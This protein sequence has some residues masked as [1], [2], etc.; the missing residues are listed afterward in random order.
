MPQAGRNDAPCGRKEFDAVILS[1]IVAGGDLDAAGRAALA[2]EHAC[3]GRG[4]D[5]GVDGVS[6]HGLQGGSDGRRQ[7]LAGGPAIAADQDRARRGDGR[8]GRG[9]SGGHL[10]RQVLA[11]HAA[12]SGNA[13]NQF[14][15]DKIP[16][17][18]GT[19]QELVP[20]NRLPARLFP[21]TS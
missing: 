18:D 13:N 7:H 10:R 3:G 12:Q 17:T 14:S 6:S 19:A 8:K 11:H 15:H 1:G 16:Y 5:A 4:Q 21:F 9:I 20:S 2:Q